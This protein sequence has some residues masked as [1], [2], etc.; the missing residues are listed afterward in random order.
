MVFENAM[1][2]GD[3]PLNIWSCKSC[4]GRA[5]SHLSFQHDTNDESKASVDTL[6]VATSSD[7]WSFQHFIDRVAA[8]CSQAQLVVPATK[9]VDTVIVSGGSQVN[10]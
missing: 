5:V 9:K 2:I 4:M 3:P 6:I 7:S 10:R 8:V 1:F